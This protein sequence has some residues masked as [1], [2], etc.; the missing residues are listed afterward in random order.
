MNSRALPSDEVRELL[1]EIAGQR[2]SVLFDRPRLALA[3]RRRVPL[4]EAEQQL[5]DV[6]QHELA[7]LLF[8]EAQC[9]FGR[10]HGPV[11]GFFPAR[12]ATVLE[13]EIDVRRVQ[14][15]RSARELDVQRPPQL[16][17]ARDQSARAVRLLEASLDLI[18]DALVRAFLGLV[19]APQG[20]PEAALRTG[21]RSL[22]ARGDTCCQYQARN[23]SKIPFVH[24]V[25]PT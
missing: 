15:E 23:F 3:R 25:S 9:C 18:P 12:S 17:H 20:A 8:L 7:A 4:S 10:V 21:L 16:V 13:R 2:F 22:E 1:G 11:D 24:A 19:E 6:H 5:V 14:V